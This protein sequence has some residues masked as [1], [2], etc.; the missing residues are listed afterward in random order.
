MST[1]TTDLIRTGKSYTVAQA[2]RLARTSP[3]NVRNWLVGRSTPGHE[4]AS[5]L[6]KAK[7][8]GSPLGV[9]FLELA[10]VIVVA[11]YRN[12]EG[13]TIPL[14]RL[15]AAHAYARTEMAIEYPFASGK[16]KHLGGHIIHEY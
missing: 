12:G 7:P 4:I 16:F 3:Q 8:D 2:A 6:G 13:K 1:S 14:H 10:E 5:V 11:R 15:R 9:S